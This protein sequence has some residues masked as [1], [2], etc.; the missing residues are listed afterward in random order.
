MGCAFVFLPNF[1]EAERCFLEALRINPANEKS[2]FN[3]ACLYSLQKD[4]PGALER[5]ACAIELNPANRH[6]AQTDADFEWLWSDEDFKN[7]VR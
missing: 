5:L 2:V 7:M 3:L 6:K 4:K 1:A